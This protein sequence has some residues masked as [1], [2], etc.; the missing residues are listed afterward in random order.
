M[1]RMKCAG[2]KF[3]AR[4]GKVKM[5]VQELQTTLKVD[6]MSTDEPFN[7]R[8]IRYLQLGVVQRSYA[9]VFP[10]D[11]PIIVVMPPA[12]ACDACCGERKWV[13]ASIP[14]GVVM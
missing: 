12:S 6:R 7:R 11:I 5:L 1:S 10:G 3:L 13:C 8:P 14:P 2:A 9:G 4:V